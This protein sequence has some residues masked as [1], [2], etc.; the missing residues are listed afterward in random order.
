MEKIVIK[1]K[2]K[3]RR[4]EEPTQDDAVKVF[5]AVKKAFKEAYKV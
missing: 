1:V 3:V 5:E 4:G 2:E